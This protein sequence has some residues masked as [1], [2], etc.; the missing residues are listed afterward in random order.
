MNC[1]RFDAVLKICAYPDMVALCQR[2]VGGRKENINK[3]RTGEQEWDTGESK[4]SP[5]E[6][7]DGMTLWLQCMN[8]L[9][10]QRDK[11][12]QLISNARLPQQC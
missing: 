12:L 4:S 11:L 6:T 1:G 7:W 2:G 8:N 10:T 9:Y 3:G 5:D